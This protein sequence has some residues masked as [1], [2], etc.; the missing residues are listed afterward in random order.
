MRRPL[1]L[2]LALA[3]LAAPALFAE[4][5][6]NAKVTIAWPVDDKVLERGEGA[7]R[8]GVSGFE[9]GKGKGH[10]HLVLDDKDAVC[11][12]DHTTSLEKLNGGVPLDE[13]THILTVFAAQASHLAVRNEAAVSQVRFH[14][15]KKK[16]DAPGPGDPH[17]V[18]NWPR[19]TLPAGKDVVL[20]FV[21]VGAKLGEG[22]CRVKAQ[23]VTGG[24]RKDSATFADLALTDAAP[25][26]VIKE[27]KPGTYEVMIE[28]EDKDGKRLP[29]V[30]GEKVARVKADFE[31]FLNAIPSYELDTG[32]YPKTLGDLVAHGSSEGGWK[33]PYV[34]DESHLRDPWGHAYAYKHE[35]GRSD[36]LITSYGSDGV[37][38][39]YGTAEDLGSDTISKLD[40]VDPFV[41]IVRELTVK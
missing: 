18:Y 19:G 15:K 36:F 9:T 25:V 21:V 35:Y 24:R 38:G 26:T 2:A 6:A 13:G 1:A 12:D 11:D 10:V 33:G 8:Y 4:E 14:V 17:L 40:P 29:G 31:M 22:A 41:R 37:T 30:Y 23:V 34:K 16:G 7:V 32:H 20:D 3:A 27:A 39:G 28:L 5:P